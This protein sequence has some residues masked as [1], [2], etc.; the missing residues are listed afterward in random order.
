MGLPLTENSLAFGPNYIQNSIFPSGFSISQRPFFGVALKLELHKVKKQSSRIIAAS[1]LA[2]RSVVD[3]KEFQFKPSFDEY[4]K[5]LES[6]KT[7]REK[8]GPQTS[9]KDGNLRGKRANQNY[10]SKDSDGKD[11]SFS[12]RD[13]E[14]RELRDSKGE[15]SIAVMGKEGKDDR[16]SKNVTVNKKKLELKKMRKP[17]QKSLSSSEDDSNDSEALRIIDR[18]A[19]KPLEQLDDV[20]DKP[21]ITRADMEERIQK[22]AKCL[23]GADID[24]PEWMFSKMMRSAKIRFSDHSVLRIIQI[25]GKLGNWRRVLQVIEWIQSHERFKSRKLRFIYTTALNVLGKSRRPVEALNL[26]QLMQQQMCTYPDLVAYHCIAVTLGQAGHMKELLH[27]IDCM[28]S[29]PKKK[30]KTGFLE[31]WDP[32]LE[33]DIVVYNAVLNACVRRK[34]WEGAFWVLQQ[35]KQQGQPP[36]STTYGL[37][38][39]LQSILHTIKFLSENTVVQ[40]G[41]FFNNVS[42]HFLYLELLFYN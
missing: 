14:D 15:I 32:R 18:A 29:L 25:L 36:S 17:M 21:R 41:I 34:N 39:E 4:L 26:F 5:A 28:R 30:F 9:G 24:M 23:N 20:Y 19:F 35:L 1:L 12:K 10:T 31:K 3:E 6:V 11:C 42:I 27:V 2:N 7:G 40:V 13:D 16:F 33:P 8:Q 38:M 22:L 37:V